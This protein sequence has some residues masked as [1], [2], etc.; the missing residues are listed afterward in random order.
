MWVERR[1]IMII[2]SRTGNVIKLRIM[3]LFSF[4]KPLSLGVFVALFSCHKGT[5]AQRFH[6]EFS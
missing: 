5:K 4:V 1:Q 3:I 6:K 2:S